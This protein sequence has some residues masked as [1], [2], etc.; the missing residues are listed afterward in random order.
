V[1]DLGPV[2]V[3]VLAFPDD[4]GDVMAVLDLVGAS[5]DIRLI[6]ALVVVKDHTGQVSGTELGERENLQGL[7]AR[8]P[9]GGPLGLLGTDD[10]REVGLLLDP[11]TWALALLVEHVWA[12]DVFRAVRSGKGQLLA[13]VRIPAESITAAE[14]ALTEESAAAS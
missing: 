7:A 5:G 11:G 6:D 14:R 2:D 9:A 13:T 8:L 12:R 10:I 3:V 1:T 4:V